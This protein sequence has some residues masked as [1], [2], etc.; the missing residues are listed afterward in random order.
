MENYDRQLAIMLFILSAIG[1]VTFLVIQIMD[2]KF[3]KGR[4]RDGTPGQRFVTEVQNRR[5]IVEKGMILL[6]TALCFGLGV[7]MLFK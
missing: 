4:Q 7:S 3:Y 2:K 6:M 5:A 1:I